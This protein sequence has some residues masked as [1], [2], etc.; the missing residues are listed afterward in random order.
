MPPGER[1]LSIG[2][3]AAATGLSP[4]TLRHYDEI[5]LLVPE[6]VDPDTGYRWY[7]PA[8]GRRA[9]LIRRLRAT[10]MPLRDV[11]D[12][13]GSIGDTSRIQ[14]ILDDHASRLVAAVVAAI[15]AQDEFATLTKEILAMSSA[16]ERPALLGPAAAIRVFVRDLDEARRF[17]GRQ[18]RL[19]ELSVTPD[20]LVLDA[21][22]VQLIVERDD[23]D[24][25]EGATGRFTGFSFSVEDAQRVCDELDELGVEI[26]GRPEPQ[27][28]G[29]TLAH[30]ADPSGNVLTLVQYPRPD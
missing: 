5:G 1:L 29:G 26:V 28:W 20:W 25:G 3:F 2:Q 14:L 30:I 13:V 6:R 16:T 24:A 23:G 8:Q 19:P 22:S 17:Y 18:L 12:V 7:A 11:A 10:D 27:V 4:T 9:D 15:R 21:G